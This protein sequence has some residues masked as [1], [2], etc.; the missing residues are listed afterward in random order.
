LT[1]RWFL[2]YIAFVEDSHEIFAYME[3][4]MPRKATGNYAKKHPD[5]RKVN[6]DI[7]KTVRKLT[8]NGEITCAVA[9]SISNE[10]K[11]AEEEIG[12]TADHLEIPITKCQLGLFGYRP[13]KKIIEPVET[14]SREL[15]D[16]IRKSL[17]SGRLSCAAAWEIADRSGIDKMKVSSACEALK[18][19]IGTCQLGAF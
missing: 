7:A 11:I 16:V 13:Q 5:D 18:I 10:L 17:A 3:V 9:F 15:E 1:K 14:V 6:P 4:K 8:V 2:L 19:K 12:F